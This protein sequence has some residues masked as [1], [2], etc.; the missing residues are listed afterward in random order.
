[1]SLAQTMYWVCSDVLSLILQLRNSQDLPAPDILQRRVLGLFDTMMKN[2]SEAR[3]AE[4]DMIDVK[5][6]LAAFADEVI[7]HSNWPG[8]TQWLNNPLQLQFF[9][10]NTASPPRKCDL[11]SIS[12]SY[13]RCPRECPGVAITLNARSPA[14]T[15]SPSANSPSTGHGCQR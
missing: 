13:E 5:Y 4:Q 8:R 2:G 15:V 12:N 6:A 7:Y 3:I 10:E 1:M 11:P 9:Q 14:S